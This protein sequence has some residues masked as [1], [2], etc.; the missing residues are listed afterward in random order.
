MDTRI[1]TE[2]MYILKQECKLYR[3]TFTISFL[4]GGW[5]F[6]CI[7][8]N[9][10]KEA[11]NEFNHTILELFPSRFYTVTNVSKAFN[12]GGATCEEEE[13][14]AFVD[15]VDEDINEGGQNA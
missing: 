10:R 4:D 6:Y 8:A 1:D 7:Y 9:N 11:I 13:E 2:E 5:T 15:F 12:I 3:Y 14:E